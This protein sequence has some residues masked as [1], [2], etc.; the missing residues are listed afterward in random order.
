[1]S[2]KIELSINCYAIACHQVV[3]L[4]AKLVCVSPSN[5]EKC[6]FFY[7]IVMYWLCPF[8]EHGPDQAGVL[9]TPPKT[10]PD[11][12]VERT[13]ITSYLYIKGIFMLQNS[14]ELFL[15]NGPTYIAHLVFEWKSFWETCYGLCAAM[16]AVLHPAMCF[17]F[18]IVIY[19]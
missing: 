7:S 2:D 18:S 6:K 10:P 15:G 11:L 14:T 5:S 17:G 1:M 4:P 8:N 13:F 12:I 19:C 16:Q 3:V 9:H